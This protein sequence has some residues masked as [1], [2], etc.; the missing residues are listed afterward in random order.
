MSNSMYKAGLAIFSVC[1]FCNITAAQNTTADSLLQLLKIAKDDTAKV[2]LLRNIGVAYSNEDPAKAIEYWKQGV[3]LSRK[4]NYTLGLAR[5]FINIGTGFAYLS[6]YDSSIIYGDSGIVYAKKINEPDRLALVYL[7]KGDNYRN[8]GNYA[9]ALLYCDTASVY[10]AK[11]GNTDRLARI[12]D[13]ISSIYA[14]QMQFPNAILFLNKAIDLY[15]KDNNAV[16][17]GQSYDDFSDIYKLMGKPDSALL[18]RKMAISIGEKEKDFKNL[19][20]YYYGAAAIYSDMHRYSDAETYVRKSIESAREQNNNSHLASSHVLLGEIY[21]KREKFTEAVTVGTMAYDY[22]T[23]EVQIGWQQ[24]AA[25]LL[26]EAYTKT[27]DY[28]NA[29][30]FLNISTELQD[31]LTKQ[32]FSSQVGSLQSSFELKEKDKAIQLLNKDKELREQ[33]LKERDQLLVAA[34]VIVS[35]ILLG[36]WL[37]YN[38]SKL[39][40]RMKELELRGKIA[41]DLHDEVGSTLSSIRMYSDIV[42]NQTPEHGNSR[43]LL[44]KISSNSKEMI[45]NMSDIVWMIK[46]GNDEFKNIENRMLN[47]ASE[48]CAPAGIA[49][50]FSKEEKIGELKLPMKQRRDLYLVFK[51]AINNAAKYADCSAISV[52]MFITPHQLHMHISDNGKGFDIATAKPGNGL[53]NMENRIRSWKGDFVIRTAPGEGTEIRVMLPV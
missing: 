42:K 50:E 7:N 45:D 37:L 19:S 29:N 14:V 48:L 10:A 2:M 18:L 6:K 23:R 51:E 41:A 47:F 33:Q 53:S 3:A 25:A 31:S 27:G 5:N 15:K 49:F 38:R 34:A 1:F 8:L 11:K 24:Q 44:D 4:L 26:A 16:M 52:R 39:T 20:V 40:Q 12:Y 28:K 36:L 35:L 21:L 22:A 30:K 13:I 46:P 17:L 43:E 9:A 32:L